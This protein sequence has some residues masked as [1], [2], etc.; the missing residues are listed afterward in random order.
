RLQ[1]DRDMAILFITHDLGLVREAADRALILYR[2]RLLEEGPVPTVF[3]AARHPYTRALLA[4]RPAN[5]PK[6]HRLPVVEDFWQGNDD[7][8]AP[9]GRPSSGAG[10]TSPAVRPVPA[11]RPSPAAP[12]TTAPDTTAPGQDVLLRIENLQVHF[13]TRHAPPVKA[14]DDVSF[15]IREGEILGLVGESGSGKT[16]IGRALLR[17]IPITHG[18]ILHRERDMKTLKTSDFRRDL[19]IVFQDPYSALNPRMTLGQTLR[20][21]L[22]KAGAATQ[23]TAAGIPGTSGTAT[24]RTPADMLD[25]VHLPRTFA[26]KYPHECSGGQRQRIVIARALAMNP[27][28]VLFDESVSALDVSV[29]AQ[30]LNL[31]GDLKQALGFTAVFISHDLAVVRYLCDRIVVLKNGRIEETGDA[32]SVYNQPQSSYTRSLLEAIPDRTQRLP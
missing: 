10:A 23:G 9:V 27:S 24:A 17:L 18:R 20:E 26:Q 8:S 4:C 6:G 2:G 11:G 5:T 32:E 21:T 3:D 19:Q 7:S 30:I 15:D 22:K 16:T 25:L 1:R 31:I 28:F 29:Q 14:V 12:G 13:K